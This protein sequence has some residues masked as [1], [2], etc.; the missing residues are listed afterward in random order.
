[1]EN[2]FRLVDE[3][4]ARHNFDITGFDDP[5]TNSEGAPS[6]SSVNSARQG[7]SVD[8]LYV[9]D[10]ARDLQEPCGSD[11]PVRLRGSTVDSDGGPFK[12]DFGLSGKTNSESETDSEGAPLLPAFGRSGNVRVASME[13]NAPIRET[14]DGLRRPTPLPSGF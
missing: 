2:I 4:L 8:F 11:I 5:L 12:L 14:R 6:L 13:A 7:G 10:A 3:S 9:E 1:M